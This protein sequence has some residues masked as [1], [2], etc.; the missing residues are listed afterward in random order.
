MAAESA[1]GRQYPGRQYP[2]RRYPGR[3]IVQAS[4]ASNVLFAITA[5]P[6]AAGVDAFDGPA[7]GVALVLFVIS[8][9]VWCY[10]FALAVG[11]SARGDDVVVG[12]LF[13]MQGPVPK[14]VRYHLFGSLAVCLAITAGTAAAD[15]FGVLVP[16]M[17]LGL[18]GLWGARHGTFPA[19]RT[20]SA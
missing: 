7:V 4:W 2:G 11:R 3:K 20:R 14:A 8:L 5:I 10:A 12:N 9:G 18:I 6:V 13:L 15:P 19:R 17:P 16:M 1:P